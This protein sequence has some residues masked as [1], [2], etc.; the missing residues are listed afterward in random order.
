MISTVCQ[1]Y[2]GIVQTLLPDCQMTMDRPDERV[3]GL[4]PNIIKLQNITV[5]DDKAREIIRTNLVYIGS[6]Y[7]KSQC[8]QRCAGMCRAARHAGRCG[9]CGEGGRGYIGPRSY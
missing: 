3:G 6:Y 7:I 5:P 8:Q 2:L 1:E 9:G 4:N